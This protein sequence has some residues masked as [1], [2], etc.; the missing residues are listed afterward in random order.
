[1]NDCCERTAGQVKLAYLNKMEATLAK[2]R[3]DLLF[4]LE[5]ARLDLSKRQPSLLGAMRRIATAQRLLKEQ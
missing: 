1:M 3:R 4:E 5:G 2:L